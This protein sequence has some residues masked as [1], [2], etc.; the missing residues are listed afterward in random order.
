[1][2]SKAFARRRMMK[3]VFVYA[4]ALVASI[5]ATQRGVASNRMPGSVVAQ[6]N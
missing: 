3:I 5:F 4:L 6:S 2:K 1:M